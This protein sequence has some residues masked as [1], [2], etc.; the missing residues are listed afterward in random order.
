MNGVTSLQTLFF[1]ISLILYILAYIITPVLSNFL[2][3][4]AAT[5]IAHNNKLML[6]EG[7]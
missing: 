4:S 1:S 5:T 7:L 3:E 6:R 2:K